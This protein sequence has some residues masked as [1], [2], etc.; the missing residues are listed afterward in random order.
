MFDKK[1][2]VSHSDTYLTWKV[3]CDALTE[4][5]I[6][7]LAWIISQDRKFNSVIG[8]LRGGVKLAEALTPYCDSASDIIL[9][10]DDVLTTGG[11]ME[12]VRIKAQEQYVG[13]DFRGIVIFCRNIEKC[14]SW[15]EPIFILSKGFSKI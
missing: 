9:I 14:P 10:V 3:E 13:F 12:E 6:Q 11:S 2:F 15:V 4:T 5:D 1:D 7:T 8:V